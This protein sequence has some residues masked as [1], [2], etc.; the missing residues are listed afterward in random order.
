MKFTSH[1]RSWRSTWIHSACRKTSFAQ[2]QCSVVL[3]N[4]IYIEMY[5]R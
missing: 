4:R 1:K 5:C 3:Y 2:Q